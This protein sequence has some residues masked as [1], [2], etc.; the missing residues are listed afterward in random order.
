MND[1]KLTLWERYLT[2][3]IGIE[4]KACLY[5]FA[6]L[7]YYSVYRI[8]VGRWDADIIHMAEMIFSCY[9]ICYIQVYLF[10]NFDEAEKPGIREIA[11]LIICKLCGRKM[12]FRRATTPNKPDYLVCHAR[13][14]PNVSAPLYLV[15]NKLIQSLEQWIKHYELE[16][17]EPVRTSS[18]SGE[19]CAI[20]AAISAKNKK[21][22]TLNNQL[23][24]AYDLLEQ[25]VYTADDFIARKSDLSSR[26]ETARA[27]LDRLRQ[28]A[29]R[30]ERQEKAVTEFIPHVKTI[31]QA[32]QEASTATAKNELL[33]EILE[34]A[35]YYKEKSG[36]F[37]GQSVDNFI[38]ELYPRLPECE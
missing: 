11:G 22:D 28:E 35:V 20:Q 29:N 7:F 31:L 19:I 24:R 9:I 36:A 13:A 38:I 15:E 26:I 23:K 17:S 5:F 4:F 12:T 6:I 32:Y 33:R 30:T 10:G 27:D 37:R 1:K 3:E 34:K 25:G 16:I 18:A 2:R 14:C 8:A 21:L